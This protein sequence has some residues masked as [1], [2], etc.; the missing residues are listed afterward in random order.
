MPR[1]LR[2][3]ISGQG[4]EVEV[5]QPQR[6]ACLNLSGWSSSK[7][8]ATSWAAISTNWRRSFGAILARTSV[9]SRSQGATPAWAVATV[10]VPFTHSNVTRAT[11]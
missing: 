9:P 4:I 6:P 10:R 2:P 11:R 1:S 3:D 8:L 5:R 7:V